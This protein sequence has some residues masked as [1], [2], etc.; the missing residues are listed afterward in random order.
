M[1]TTAL[2]SPITLN[3][4]IIALLF[5]AVV[6]VSVTG[7]RVPLLSNARV[8]IIALIVLGMA[9]CTQGGIGRIAAANQW[10]HPQAIIG[11]ILGATILVIALA[12]VFGMKLPFIQ[13]ETQAIVI[14]ALLTS[15][16]I[17]N[18]VLHNFLSRSS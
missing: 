10:T 8:A 6:F 14:V 12:T 7:K 9:M 4:V 2:S 3:V 5:A 15:V 16:K 1:K 18:A 17:A 13:N 11:Y